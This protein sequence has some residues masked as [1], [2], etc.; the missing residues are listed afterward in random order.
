MYKQNIDRSNN[1]RF[2]RWCRKGYAIFCSIKRCVTIAVL[3]EKIADCSVAKSKK[4]ILKVDLSS[5]LTLCG[6][7]VDECLDENEDIDLA[8]VQRLIEVQSLASVQCAVSAPRY[9]VARCSIVQCSIV[10]CSAESIP[11]FRY[12][13][14]KLNLLQCRL[15]IG[16]N[17]HTPH[18]C[19]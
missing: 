7:S 10:R 18:L 12:K 17:L 1:I 3:P 4:N 5:S 9:S 19:T 13:D 15:C 14:I 16:A 8:G 6:R 11:Y 2:S